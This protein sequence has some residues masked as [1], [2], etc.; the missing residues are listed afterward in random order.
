MERTSGRGRIY[1][2]S[3]VQREVADGVMP[4][5]VAAYVDLVEQDGL[6]VV[7]N[8]VNVWIHDVRIGMDV[9]VTFHDIASTATLAYFEPIRS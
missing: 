6:R 4:P 8:I 7:S 2:F 1:S 3:V 9:K 5:Y